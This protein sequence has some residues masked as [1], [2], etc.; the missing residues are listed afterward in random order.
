MGIGDCMSKRK[1]LIVGALQTLPFTLGVILSLSAVANLAGFAASG[2]DYEEPFFWIFLV[3]SM[4]GIPLSLLGINIL[5][6]K[7]S[8]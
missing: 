6:H 1:S 4:I 7:E 3:L 2:C 5:P 8:P